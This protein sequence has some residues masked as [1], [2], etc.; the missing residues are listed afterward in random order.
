MLVDGPHFQATDGGELVFLLSDGDTSR[1]PEGHAIVELEEEG[2][3]RQNYYLRV[4]LEHPD[5]QRWRAEI[6]KY[7]APLVLSTTMGRLPWTLA[8][9]P[10]GYDLLLHLSP[11]RTKS[12]RPRRDFY[13]YGSTDV[14]NFASPLEFVKHAK[15]LMQGAPRT[16]DRDRSPRCKCKYCNPDDS[17]DIQSVISRELRRVRARVLARIDG[18]EVQDSEDDADA[19]A[20]PDADAEVSAGVGAGAEAEVV[21]A[22]TATAVPATDQGNAGRDGN[23]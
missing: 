15:W 6:A 8:D 1:R 11:S 5:S 3:V 9:F 14:A 7:L 12:S 17:G 22:E 21:M 20:D 19:D 13:L 18:D 4:P 2:T 23:Q 16:L 10:H